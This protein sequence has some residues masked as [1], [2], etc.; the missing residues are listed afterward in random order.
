MLTSE[1]YYK[2]NRSYGFSLQLSF[3]MW[4]LWLGFTSPKW[5]K[6]SLS[7]VQKSSALYPYQMPTGKSD[8]RGHHPSDQ[9]SGPLNHSNSSVK[10]YVLHHMLLPQ[11]SFYIFQVE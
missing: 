6:I 8:H 10:E 4:P 5:L 7:M 2:F 9:G 11:Q 1:V 3:S